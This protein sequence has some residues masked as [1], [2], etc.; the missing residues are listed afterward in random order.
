MTSTRRRILFSLALFVGL[1]PTGARATSD[2]TLST[3]DDQVRWSGGPVSGRTTVLPLPESCTA[4]DCDE[5]TLT[6]AL[7][8]GTFRTRGGV[9]VSI[10]WADE[11][12]DLDLYVYNPDGTL[13]AKSEGIVSTAESV[14]VRAPA[15]GDYRVLVAA[16]SADG[17]AYESS[18][19]VEFPPAAKPARDL[20]PDLISLRPR[21]LHFETSAYLFHLPVPSMPGGC[22]PEEIAEQGARRC[23]RF[24]QI[25][26]NSGRGPFELRYRI[27]GIA[28]EDTRDL[29]QRVYRTDGSLRER[30]ADTYTFH[31]AHAHFHYS[32]FARSYLWRATPKGVRV[33]TKPVRSS[34]KNG[35]CMVDVEQTGFGTRGDSPRTYIPPGCLAPT[36]FDTATGALAAVSGIS[37]GWADVYNWYLADQFIE[38]SGLRDGYY[39]LENVADQAG[40]VEEIDDSNNAASTL[41]RLCGDRAEIVGIDRRCREGT[42]RTKRSPP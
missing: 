26:A 10:R 1:L 41:I 6:L 24:D 34:R 13:A 36:E 4:Q 18:A 23:L 20:L 39:E 19:E 12:Q 15:N 42:R 16:T 35:F 32:N 37:P 17:V 9:Q 30:V 28:T 14:L 8:R 38:V 5:R 27:D 22:Y 25:V 33:G 2:N 7:P 31:A 3:I 11:E 40:T 21:N 29:V